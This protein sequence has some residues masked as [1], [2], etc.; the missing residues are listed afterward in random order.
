MMRGFQWSLMSASFS[1]R[2]ILFIAVDSRQRA[3]EQFKPRTKVLKR[4]QD[5]SPTNPCAGY[6]VLTSGYSFIGHKS[7]RAVSPNGTQPSLI[8][9]APVLDSM[10]HNLPDA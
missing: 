9:D 2:L 4:T 5:C 3:D 6:W 8:A 1:R 7:H 10:F